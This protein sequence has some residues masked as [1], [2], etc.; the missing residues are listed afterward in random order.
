M[1]SFTP[2]PPYPPGKDR[3][4]RWVG[5]WLGP[6]SDLDRVRREQF[7]PGIEPSFRGRPACSLVNILNELC[8][9]YA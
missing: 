2:R 8:V 4:T 6:T 9:H 5:G 3:R 7:L 1:V